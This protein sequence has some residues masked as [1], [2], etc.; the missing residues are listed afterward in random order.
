MT[1]SRAW[2]GAQSAQ[3]GHGLRATLAGEGGGLS[4]APLRG[5]GCAGSPFPP[6][7][8]GRRR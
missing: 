7:E 3:T 8:G 1:P 4:P 2:I 5:G 6:A